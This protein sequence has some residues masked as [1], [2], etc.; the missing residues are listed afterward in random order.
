MKLVLASSSPYR[1]ELLQRLGHAF[2][3][4]APDV[5]E[6]P[7]P[8]EPA[9]ELAVRLARAK[10]EAVRARHPDAWVVGSDQVAALGDDLLHKPGTASAACEQ[11]RRLSG[12]THQLVTA[13]CVVAPT[14]VAEDVVVHDMRMRALTD[15]EIEHYVATDEP[16]D[17]AGAYRIEAAGIGL[18]ESLRGDDYT[19]IVGLPLT[20][21]RR[22]LSALDFDW[23]VR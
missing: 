8:G 2:E 7:R 19:A 21:V 22:L 10:A 20:T 1:R 3:S 5:D 14:G 4:V 11:L 6:M 18:F 9:T 12:R 23:G 16:L 13:V 17:C 15:A